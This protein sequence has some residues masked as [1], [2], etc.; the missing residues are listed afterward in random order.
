MSSPT[1]EQVLELAKEHSDH[2]NFPF[3]QEKVGRFYN[4][5]VTNPMGFVFGDSEKYLAALVVEHPILPGLVGMELGLY[6]RD[7]KG[8]EL[9]KQ[10]EDWS[11]SKGASRTFMTSYTPKDVSK[12]YQR[13][14]YS[15]YEQ[16]FIKELV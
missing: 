3:D 5:I 9:V 14:G 4:S 16:S 8:K 11:K 12:Y 1:I 2:F 6:A 7:H 13:L 15:L 10:F